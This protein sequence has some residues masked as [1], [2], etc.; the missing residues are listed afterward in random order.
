[1]NAAAAY[2][3]LLRFGK[4]IL[5]TGDVALRLGVGLPAAS[6][7]MGRLA[8]TGLVRQLRRGVWE[9][10]QRVE[11]LAIPEYLMGASPSYISFQSALFHHGMISQIPQVRYV[12]SLARPQVVKTTAGTYSVH[13]LAPEF[14]GGY[15]KGP[16]GAMIATPEKALVDVLYL[17]SSRDRKFS[18]LPELEL[19]ESFSTAAVLEWVAQIRDP[20]RRGMV[21]R[22]LRALGIASSPPMAHPAPVGNRASANG[23]VDG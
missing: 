20:R 10:G 8:L 1:M 12:A 22:R 11:P 9:V 6:R 17:S 13:Q 14:F 2:A 5:R 23:E 3:N 19:P 15:Q 7:M 18:R 4:P 21:M 16:S